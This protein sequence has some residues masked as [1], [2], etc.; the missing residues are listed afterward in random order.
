MPKTKSDKTETLR[1]ELQNS[2][3]EQLDKIAN[4]I[5]FRN[6]MKPVV[7][8]ASDN[9]LFYLVLVPI[10]TIIASSIGLVWSYRAGLLDTPLD[11]FNDFFSAYTEAKDNG[12]V[13]ALTVA[14]I[15]GLSAAGFGSNNFLVNQA[16]QNP[17]QFAEVLA[18][19]DFVGIATDPSTYIDPLLDLRP[20]NP[21]GVNS[22]LDPVANNVDSLIS[23]IQS[24]VS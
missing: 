1:I 15:S 4:S 11:V 23:W 21:L 7:D 6:Y 19:I 12:L 17:D 8:I 24:Q 9:T 22:A 13:P 2:E 3:R 16:N 10:L 14:T 5:A 20:N 18:G